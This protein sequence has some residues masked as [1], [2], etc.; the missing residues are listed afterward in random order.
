MRNFPLQKN[1]A[2]KLLS[3]LGKTWD[4]NDG[5][6]VFQTDKGWKATK[7]KNGQY[8]KWTESAYPTRE[9]ALQNL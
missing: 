2:G 1:Q 7:V 8:V 4:R 9:E 5:E 6:H 3:E